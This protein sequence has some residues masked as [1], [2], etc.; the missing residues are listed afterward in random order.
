VKEAV[1]PFIKFPGVDTILGPEMKSTGEVMGVGKSFAE[2]FVKSQLAAGD[3]LPRTGKVF[4]SVRQSDKNGAV[5]VARELQRL[6]F[7]VCATRGTAKTLAE[8]GIVVQVVNKVN[9]GRPHIVDMIKNGEI[10]VLVNTVDEKRQAIQD[11]HSIRRSALQ[12][13]VP[14]TPPWPVPRQCAWAW[15]MWKSLMSTASRNCT[16]PSSLDVVD[17][18]NVTASCALKL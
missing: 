4:L 5:D 8:A 6:G 18:R 7:G 9:E 15:R 16:P 2:A 10:D 14:S 3:K 11:S 17:C 12:A 13:R 1:F